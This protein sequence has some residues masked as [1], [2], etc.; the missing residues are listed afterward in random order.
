MKPERDSEE[1]HA[2]K[3]NAL[4]THIQKGI[5]CG[6]PVISFVYETPTAEEK[7]KIASTTA[8]SATKSKS[9]KN[10]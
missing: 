5:L 10:N 9:Y 3:I 4:M 8:R 2:N 6:A 7:K 1:L